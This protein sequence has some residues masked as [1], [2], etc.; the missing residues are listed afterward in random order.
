MKNYFVKNGE[1]FIHVIESGEKKKDIPSL[2]VVV[3]IWESAERAMPIHNLN[4]H[5]VSFS[6]RG[7]GLSSTPDSGYDLE[8][9]LSD[10][11]KVVE[12]CKLEDYCVLGFSRGAAYTL[13]W[14]LRKETSIRGMILVDQA[15]IH[16]QVPQESLEFWCNMIYQNVPVKNHMRA[17]AFEG[18]S[19]DAQTYDFSD[20]LSSIE[21]PVRI[22]YGT[23]EH[24]DIPS[25][26]PKETRTIYAEKIEKV[27][28]VEFLDS[29]HMIPDDE[30]E[31][32]L[33]E[34]ENF[35]KILSSDL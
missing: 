21:I 10:I 13:G 2:L 3:G 19:R 16:R 15:P 24:S 11:R 14:Y 32:Y 27:S 33:N 28:F 20:E 9:H 29:G 1:T 4:R 18:L 7:R 34:I 31:K 30:T 12:A 5:V 23:S 8:D 6:F 22:F 35:L 25:N 26:L 17:L